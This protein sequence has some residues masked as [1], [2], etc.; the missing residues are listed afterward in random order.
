MLPGQRDDDIDALLASGDGSLEELLE[1]LALD[2]EWPGEE[3]EDFG[4][5]QEA[6]VSALLK[7]LQGT[8]GSEPSWASLGEDGRRRER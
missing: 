6:Q 2:A 7:K 5:E 8:A 4:A 3:T 1:E